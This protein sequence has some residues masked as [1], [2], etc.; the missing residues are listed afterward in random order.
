[1]MSF[2]NRA[3]ASALAAAATAALLAA[4]PLSAASV[5]NQA[6]GGS[7][8]VDTNWTP[9]GI[10]NSTGA[11]ATFNGAATPSNPAQTGNRTIT[12]DAPQTV[13]SIVFNNDLSTFTNSLT[14]GTA[15]ALTLDETGAGPAT[16][17]VPAA[18][19]TGN[20]TISAP[21]TLTDSVVATVDN[22][23]ATSAAGALNLTATMSGPGGF[24]KNGP[25]LATFG[26]GLKTYAGPTVLNGGRTRISNAAF[27]TGTSSFTINAGAQLEL[28]TNGTY[29]F[30]S[31]NGSLNLNGSGAA[32]G[33]FAQFPGAIRNT[34][35][36]QATI[37]NPVVLQSDTLIH[38]QATAGTGANP[39]LT[40]GLTEFS[41]VVSGPGRLTLTAPN[42]DIDQGYLVL[43]GANTY[44]GGTIVAGGIVRVSGAA[45]TLGA[46][47]VTVSNATSPLSIARLQILSGVAD[48]ISDTATLT[49]AG[50]G[51][52]GVPDANWADLATGLDERIGAL[53]L[54]GVPQPPGSYGSTASPATFKNDEFFSGAG[55]V[56]VVPEPTALSLAAMAGLGLLARRRRGA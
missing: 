13:G 50:G 24:T 47:N 28:I 30:N 27:S 34:R 12:L 51:A 15:G 41:G 19:G 52:P 16:I 17:N 55:V 38:V 5:W 3:S 39:A 6:G 40:N 35:A 49:L 44:T 8:N 14:V 46:G 1:M 25:G 42:S 45:A 26:T 48:A 56:T 10:P 31:N 21:I 4:K 9:T 53:I 54:A 32:T 36:V 43:S 33:P 22:V 7:W 2:R 29:T 23:T 18:A 11:N 37:T 20:N